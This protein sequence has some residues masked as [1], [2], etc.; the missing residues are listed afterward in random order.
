MSNCQTQETFVNFG[1]TV[2]PVSPSVK[3]MIPPTI[4]E[5]TPLTP[6]TEQLESSFIVP[7]TPLIQ[8]SEQILSD[9]THAEMTP[10]SPST[11][12]MD[13]VSP[14]VEIIPL[15]TFTEQLLS[16]STSF[17]LRHVTPRELRPLPQ[18]SQETPSGPRPKSN[19][20]TINIYR[21]IGQPFSVKVRQKNLKLYLEQET[22][23]HDSVLYSNRPN[24]SSS[25]DRQLMWFHDFL[26]GVGGPLCRRPL[27][28]NL[29]LI[30]PRRP[31]ATTLELTMDE[32]SLPDPTK[33]SP[34]VSGYE[35]AGMPTPLSLATKVVLA[36]PASAVVHPLDPSRSLTSICG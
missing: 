29:C 25:S 34:P 17:A 24:R 23:D 3:M 18:V 33:D 13:S 16:D 35:A 10:L 2:H 11:E 9:S 6:S 27:F 14:S 30:R 21:S 22:R 28:S 7:M 5:M 1:N 12:M 19:N 31:S 32:G 36:R 26:P 15:P 4:L 8:S 20:R